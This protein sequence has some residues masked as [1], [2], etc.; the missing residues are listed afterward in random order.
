MRRNTLL[1]GVL[2]LTA[3]FIH[4]P[5][6]E[7]QQSPEGAFISF[8]GDID[9]QQSWHLS[10]FAIQNESFRTAWARRAIVADPEGG[11]RLTIAPAPDGADKDFV[12]AEVQR[13][14]RTHFGHYEVVMRA[15]RGHGVISSFFTYTGPYFGDPHEEIDFEF[16]GRD[17]TKVWLN[18]F[19][20]GEKLPGQWIELGFDASEA[21]HLYAF[22]WLPDRI[23]WYADGE[24]I[25]RVTADER[26]IP[27]TPGKI[28]I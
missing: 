13:S 9:D 23:V 18:R 12:G 25:F 3:P 14:R 16:L 6:V 1:S 28:Y 19:Y 21:P 8:M 5:P 2:L 17:P 15:A 24:E 4:V 10:N 27:S 20:D 26:G 11:V 7:S 22:D